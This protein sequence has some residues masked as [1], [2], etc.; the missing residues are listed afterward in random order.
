MKARSTSQR[1]ACIENIRQMEGAKEQW[2][3]QNQKFQGD[4]VVTSEVTAYLKDGKM[5]A[6]PGGGTYT[7]N[8]IGTDAACSLTAHAP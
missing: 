8:V 6:C 7:L 2:A 3:M 4:T 1:N 5:P